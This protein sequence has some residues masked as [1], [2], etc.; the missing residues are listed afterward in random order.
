M[1]IIK[2]FFKRFFIDGMVGLSIGLFATIVAGTILE[3][4]GLVMGGEIG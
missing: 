4:I 2:T 3:T 1:S